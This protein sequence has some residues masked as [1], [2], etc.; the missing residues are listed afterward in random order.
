MISIAMAAYNGEKFIREQIDSILNQTYQDFELIICDD[1]STDSTWGILQEYEQRDKRIHCFFNK[2]NLGFNKNFEKAIRL[3]KGEYIAISDQ[4]D[5]WTKDHLAVLLESIED[6]LICCGDSMLITANGETIYKFSEVVDNI[7]LIDTA[8]KKMLRILYGGGPFSGACMLIKAEALQR[9][10]PIPDFVRFYDVWFALCTCV[11]DSFRYILTV[12][13]YFRQHSLNMSGSHKKWSLKRSLNNFTLIKKHQTSNRIEYCTE[14]L[15]RYKYMNQEM[16]DVL[17]SA[18]DYFRNKSNNFYRIKHLPFFVKNFP[19]IYL[20][21]SK[22]IF[23]LRLI[24]Y[25]FF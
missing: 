3:C 16:K 5:I 12:V 14:L 4:D 24:Q 23:F 6:N 2:K 9:I 22:K 20:T 17:L 13:R 25:I 11:Q 1:C 8:E 19:Y 18:E 7:S 10:L 21:R 15:K